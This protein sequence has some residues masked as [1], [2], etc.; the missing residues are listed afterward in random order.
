MKIAIFNEFI[1]EK[2]D[3]NVREIYPEGIHGQIASLFADQHTVRTFTLDNIGELT[4]QVLRDTDVMFW[5]GHVGHHRVPDAV[6]ESV[7]D[8]VLRGMGMIFLHS[9]HHSKPFRLLM[10]TPCNLGWREN[11]DW[12]RVWVCDP[13]H[14]IVQGVDR[15]FELE[16][17]EVYVE[18]FMIPEP[19]KLILIGAYQGGEAFRAGCCYRRGYGKIFYFQPGHETYR[20][21][22]H[23]A[24]QTILKNAAEW[25]KSDYRAELTCPHVEQI[26]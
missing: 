24:V 10:G 1:H 18:P 19:D 22:Y 12:E 11:G 15:Y 9:A 5:W 25:V 21:F 17:E 4:D 20:S 2:N 3:A 13:S 6:A 14:P 23:P 26:G 16:H 8:A 7:R